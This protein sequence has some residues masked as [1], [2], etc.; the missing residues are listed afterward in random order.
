ML[1]TWM[2]LHSADPN[3]HGKSEPPLRSGSELVAVL[4]ITPSCAAANDETFKANFRQAFTLLRQHAA[5][6]GFTS[7]VIGV[8]LSA[9]TAESRRFLVGLAPFDEISIGYGWLNS[10]AIDLV[11]RDH[12]GI[13]VIPQLVIL[14]RKIDVRQSAVLVSQD[15]LLLRIGGVEDINRWVLAKAPLNLN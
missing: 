8:S 15:S 14:Q 1:A 9:N 2:N 11:W 6:H 3:V 10:G 12:P 5:R 7:V 13:S 4:F